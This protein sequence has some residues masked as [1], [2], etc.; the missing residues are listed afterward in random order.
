MTMTTVVF[1]AVEIAKVGE[2]WPSLLEALEKGE[3]IHLM[4]G[5]ELKAKVIPAGRKEKRR[6]PGLHLGNA[7]VASD[8]D[9]PLPDAL[10]G[11]GE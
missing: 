10:W 4:E 9:E 1:H 2:L 5:R 11:L 3:E 8:F 7:V 6:T